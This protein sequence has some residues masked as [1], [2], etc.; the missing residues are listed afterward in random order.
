[1]VE[2]HKKDAVALT[3][4]F[5]WLENNWQS[6]V[7]EV[8]ASDQLLKFRREDEGCLG[9]SFCSISG[10]GPNGAIVHYRPER[11][12]DATIDDSSIYL[13]DSGGQYWGGTTDVTR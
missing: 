4:F 9:P 13:L 5:H 6:G 10:F 3:K 7:S 2:S 8:D 12:K 1:M 11:P